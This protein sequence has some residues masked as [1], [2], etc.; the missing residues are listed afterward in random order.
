VV[1]A[2]RR[3]APVI[4]LLVVCA[5][6]ASARGDGRPSRRDDEVFLQAAYLMRTEHVTAMNAVATAAERQYGWSGDVIDNVRTKGDI[7][8]YFLLHLWRHASDFRTGQSPW[9]RPLYVESDSLSRLSQLWFFASVF[10]L[11]WALLP[12]GRGVALA[13][14]VLLAIGHPFRYGPALFDTWVMPAA[15]ASIGCWL[16]DRHLA[17]AGLAVAATMIKPNYAFLLGA[18]LLASLIRPG[19]EDASGRAGPVP[20]AV[21]AV[22]GALLVA[23]YI[24][25]GAVDV[26]NWGSYGNGVRA[27]YNPTVLAYSL[28]ETFAFTYRAGTQQLRDHWPVFPW[29]VANIVALGVLA[30][31]AWNHRG[32]PRTTVLVVS[33]IVIPAIANFTVIDSVRAYEDGGHFRWINV[34]IIGMAIALPLAWREVARRVRATA[35]RPVAVG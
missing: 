25:L 20:A 32:L 14:A 35:R 29:T 9:G 21:Y 24:A 11:Y 13:S 26:I 28:L 12:L 15:V 19:R 17:A 22:A 2:A 27:G 3:L 5:L 23:A 18:F 4:V 8:T 16:R 6:L 7:Q 30:R 10:L 34:S 33:L 31:Q 1:P